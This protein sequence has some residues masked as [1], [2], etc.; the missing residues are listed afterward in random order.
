L[1]KLNNTRTKL[2]IDAQFCVGQTAQKVETKR[3]TKTS[4][5]KNRILFYKNYRLYILFRFLKQ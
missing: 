3:K 5:G 4:F 1:D 2:A